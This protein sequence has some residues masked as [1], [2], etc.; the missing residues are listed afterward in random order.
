[1]NRVLDEEHELSEA[2]I[3]AF[4]S[5]REQLS[6]SGRTLTKRQRQWVAGAANRVGV[7][8]PARNLVSNGKVPKQE[9]PVELAPVLKRLALKPPG[10]PQS[11]RE[12]S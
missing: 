3:D 5:M 8:L 9:K 1:L 6:E 2:E 10:K 7:A 4:Q 12:R 11:F